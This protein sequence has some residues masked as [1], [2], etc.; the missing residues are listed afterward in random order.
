MLLGNEDPGYHAFIPKPA[1]QVFNRVKDR[2]GQASCSFK[3]FLKIAFKT[4]F[5]SFPE[6][7]QTDRNQ[8]KKQQ[9]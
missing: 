9:K 8:D 3:R 2:P 6:T 7:E 5:S 4:D 1:H